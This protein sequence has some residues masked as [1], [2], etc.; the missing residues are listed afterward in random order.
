MPITPQT[1]NCHSPYG[2]TPYDTAKSPTTES[3]AT[4]KKPLFN[5]VIGFVISIV[6]RTERTPTREASTPTAPNRSGKN[7]QAIE[8]LTESAPDAL[9]KAT[10]STIAPMNSA[11]DDS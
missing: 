10:P 11:A 7:I 8:S 3:P 9:Y 2:S 1:A 6:G 5:S 4:M